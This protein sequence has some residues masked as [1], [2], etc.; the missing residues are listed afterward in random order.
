MVHGASRSRPPQRT[1]VCMSRVKFALAHAP[2]S[3]FDVIEHPMDFLTITNNLKNGEYG[4]KED[5]AAHVRLM[6]NNAYK[7]N[8]VPDAP[9]YQAAK[10][11]EG[12]LDERKW[13]SSGSLE[14][15]NRENIQFY[16]RLTAH[17]KNRRSRSRSS[18]LRLRLLSFP[19]RLL[20]L[21]QLHLHQL[22]QRPLHQLLIL[23]LMST[24]KSCR[25]RK[26]LDQNPL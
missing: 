26:Y 10:E 3:Y 18:H 7:Y 6:C 13:I 24:M 5:L 12:L 2:F 4:S 25:Q 9:A 14:G 16:A 21:H 20:H 19:L 1:K 11:I 8:Q 17:P 22:H 23:A 15:V